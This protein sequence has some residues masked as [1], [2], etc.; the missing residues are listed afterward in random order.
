MLGRK[1]TPDRK[2]TIQSRGNVNPR[3]CIQFSML[4]GRERMTKKC[5]WRTGRGSI[6]SLVSKAD[7]VKDRLI[8]LSKNI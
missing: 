5:N 4:E 8:L 7:L 6:A 3:K 1:D 2:L